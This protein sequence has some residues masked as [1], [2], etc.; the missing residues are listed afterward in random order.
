MQ[1]FV[2]EPWADIIWTRR[3]ESPGAPDPGRFRDSVVFLEEHKPML[4]GSRC[5]PLDR[6]LEASW[7]SLWRAGRREDAQVV[8]E[9]LEEQGGGVTE[10]MRRKAVRK[11]GGVLERSTR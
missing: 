1:L 2:D 8:R 6:Y 9:W 7:F 10:R 3:T 5:G 11:I 4:G